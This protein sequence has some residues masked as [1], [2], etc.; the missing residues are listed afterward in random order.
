LQRDRGIRRN[1]AKMNFG[2]FFKAATGNSPHDYQSRL[3]ESDPG[4]A[5]RR[6]KIVSRLRSISSVAKGDVAGRYVQQ[7]DSDVLEGFQDPLHHRPPFIELLPLL[8]LPIRPHVRR[9]L[10][11]S[12]KVRAGEIRISFMT[13]EQS[14]GAHSAQVKMRLIVNGDSIRITHMGPD[15]LFIESPTDHPPCEAS[16]LLR[17]DDSESEWKVRLPQ[18]ISNDSKRVAL[19]LAS[20]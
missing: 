7:I 12:I 11:P 13:A 5:R 1:R 10:G 3:A 19:G 9:K 2:E 6:T 4:W 15:F 8:R 14:Y 20:P 18:G 17:V 16:I